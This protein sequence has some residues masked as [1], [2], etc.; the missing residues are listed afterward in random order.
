MQSTQPSPSTTQSSTSLRPLQSKSFTTIRFYGQ[1]QFWISGIAVG[2]FVVICI[3][4]CMILIKIKTYVSQIGQKGIINNA[5]SLIDS[6]NA[7]IASTNI[8][9]ANSED[10][11]TSTN[12]TLA[13]ANTLMDSMQSTLNQINT[14]MGIASFSSNRTTRSPVINNNNSNTNRNNYNSNTITSSPASIASSSPRGL[15]FTP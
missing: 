10:T 4:L 15:R 14:I 11:I 5:S 1:W 3:L 13:Q 9:I 8:L 12:E 7:T 2:I 6:A